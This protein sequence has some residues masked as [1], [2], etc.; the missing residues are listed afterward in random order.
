M[1]LDVQAETLLAIE[2]IHR[3]FL[4]KGRRDAHGSHC[5]V[6]WDRV[7]MPKEL[8]GLGIIN[9]RKMNIALRTHWLWLS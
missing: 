3:G 5:L 1:S 7:C 4:R 6:A 2:K 9:L 8:G